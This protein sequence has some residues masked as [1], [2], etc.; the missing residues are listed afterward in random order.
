[1]FPADPCD[2][3]GLADP[4]FPIHPPPPPPPPPCADPGA[5]PMDDNTLCRSPTA[6]NPATGCAANVA[7]SA[8]RWSSSE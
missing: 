3:P 6:S 1:M 5:H 4:A 2:P 8:P 7:A